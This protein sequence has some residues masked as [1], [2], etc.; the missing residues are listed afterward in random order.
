MAARVI[1][2]PRYAIRCA[3]ITNSLTAAAEHTTV[4]IIYCASPIHVFE[5]SFDAQ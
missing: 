5:W 1:R 4:F 3:E 2:V